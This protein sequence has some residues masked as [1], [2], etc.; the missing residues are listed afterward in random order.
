MN[1]EP[2]SHQE[3][4]KKIIGDSPTFE[5]VKDS[6]VGKTTTKQK[7]ITLLNDEHNGRNYLLHL[8]RAYIPITKAIK[9]LYLKKGIIHRCDLCRVQIVPLQAYIN[10][11]E[12]D[13]DKY[14]NSVIDALKKSDDLLVSSDSPY[15]EMI[16]DDKSFGF[17]G[18]ETDTRLCPKCL[19]ALLQFALEGISKNNRT[20]TSVL[21]GRVL[22]QTSKK[23][24][25]TAKIEPIKMVGDDEIKKLKDKFN[26]KINYGK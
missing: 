16:G 1:N 24:N 15:K 2:K 5:P 20:I 13:I 19:D 17:R 25:T 18:F 12:Y 8:I 3:E 26:T 22:D 6:T 4:A 21:K 10:R 23:L 11:M 14:P 7:L 9:I